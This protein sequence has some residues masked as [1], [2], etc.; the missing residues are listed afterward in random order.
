MA[1]SVNGVVMENDSIAIPLATVSLLQASDSAYITG[2]IGKDDGTFS[3]DASP[4]KKLVN[5]Q[6]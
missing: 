6:G 5:R 3:F 4:D 2:C 1:Q